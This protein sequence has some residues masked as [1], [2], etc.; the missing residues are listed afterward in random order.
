[1]AEG[2]TAKAV[3]PRPVQ[4]RVHGVSGTRPETMLAQSPIEADSAT[5]QTL[6]GLSFY[7]PRPAF[8]NG[9]LD[10]LAYQWGNIT[11][12]RPIHAL[13]LLLIPFTLLN[14]AW[15]SSPRGPRRR[16]ALVRAL[17][18]TIGLAVTELVVFIL[19]KPVLINLVGGCLITPETTPS[20]IGA[21]VANVIGFNRGV[22][23]EDRTV[24]QA[25][26]VLPFGVR[27]QVWL[28]TA[29][30]LGAFLGGVRTMYRGRLSSR[31]VR[32]WL[33][34][35]SGLGNRFWTEDITKR[36]FWPAATDPMLLH[37]HVNLAA[38][39]I[40]VDAMSIVAPDE[41]YSQV[42]RAAAGWM[43][44][45]VVGAVFFTPRPRS[46][47]VG[48]HDR[49]GLLKRVFHLLLIASWP[50]ML[51]ALFLASQA[52]PR[53]RGM[54]DGTAEVASMTVG[55][56]LGDRQDLLISISVLIMV[57]FADL[58]ACHRPRCANH[59]IVE[60]VVAG[61]G[62]GGRWGQCSVGGSL[63]SVSRT[64]VG[65]SACR[66]DRGH[67]HC[68][69]RRRRGPGREFEHRANVRDRG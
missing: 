1:M 25:L 27:A 2:E 5:G 41:F 40:L 17:L 26:E 42:L 28:A 66:S 20:G 58:A 15:W 35:R 3:K 19:T 50:A 10:V 65:Q 48:E 21:R 43:A 45:L 14:L 16:E 59:N 57:G 7:G 44:A 69:G 64:L 13:R 34:G 68:G 11:A 33:L 52:E 29:L 54:A 51:V 49:V 31:Q 22:V 46:G 38:V 61:G 36:Q 56:F 62:H 12:G 67:L 60:L 37:I 47:P 6:G 63:W 9:R 30:I 53:G 55:E 18:L 39:L 23:V 4:L 8:L 24:C 32:S